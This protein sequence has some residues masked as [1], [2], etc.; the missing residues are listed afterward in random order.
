MIDSRAVNL[1]LD[2]I[3]SPVGS[4]P[5]RACLAGESVWAAIC[6]R[7]TLP[8]PSF[9]TSVFAVTERTR[10]CGLGSASLRTRNPL[11]PETCVPAL[12]AVTSPSRRLDCSLPSGQVGC[13]R[14]LFTSV[15]SLWTLCL[16]RSRDISQDTGLSTDFLGSPQDDVGH[17]Q[18]PHRLPTALRTGRPDRRGPARL[19]DSAIRLR[20]RSGRSGRRRRHA[21]R[22]RSGHIR[23][24]LALPPR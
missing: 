16:P 21:E 3:H 23:C 1:P 12:G 14:R 13:Q 18:I 7:F 15:T 5:L 22:R 2:Q 10:T 8:H 9:G 19:R 20:E 11:S 4:R 17:T 6:L 24:A